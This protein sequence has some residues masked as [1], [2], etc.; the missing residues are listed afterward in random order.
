MT[1]P[2]YFWR[3]FM[4]NFDLIQTHH[5]QRLAIDY[6]RQSSPGQVLNHKESLQL[7][8][9]LKERARLYGW[10]P[11]RIRVIDRDLGLTGR[12]AHD[13]PG[14]QELVTLVNQEQVGI[15][16]AYDVTRLARN[17]TDW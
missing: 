11:E 17:C 14:F 16:L 8:Y 15:V 1:S 4:N 7:Q 2:R 13:R 6:V 9:D 12:T 5:L 3:S 10:A